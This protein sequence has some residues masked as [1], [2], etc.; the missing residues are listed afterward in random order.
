L[1]S[2]SDYRV[3]NYPPPQQLPRR[4]PHIL[5]PRQSR[6]NQEVILSVSFVYCL[7]ELH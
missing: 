3:P 4:F 5:T 7:L 6:S 2:G 1:P